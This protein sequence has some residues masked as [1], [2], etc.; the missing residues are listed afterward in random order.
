[1]LVETTFRDVA[2]SDALTALVREQ[3]ELL[4]C[5]CDHITSCQVV[6]ERPQR[7]QR[8]ATPTACAST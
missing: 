2:A 5:F 3:A 1:M 6:V 4:G 8:S 7:H